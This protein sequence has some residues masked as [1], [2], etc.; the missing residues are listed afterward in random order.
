MEIGKRNMGALHS[1]GFQIFVADFGVGYTSLV[2]LRNLPISGVKIHKSYV[3]GALLSS[4]DAAIIRA[5]IA[6][7]HS[8]DLTV[9]GEGVDSREQCEFLRNEN[10][11]EVQGYY[12]G[13]PV[14]AADMTAV[15]R[16]RGGNCPL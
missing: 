10:C 12:I 8:M 6:M 4:E 1:K 2:Y 16:H 5:T 14:P 15:L 13:K 11:D 9:I 7:V 3:Q